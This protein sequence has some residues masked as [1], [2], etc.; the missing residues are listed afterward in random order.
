MFE[1]FSS[2][3]SSS[4]SVRMEAVD[5]MAEGST[6]KARREVRLVPANRKTAEDDDDDEKDSRTFARR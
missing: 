1:S 4:S 2:S 6:E 5:R 3:S